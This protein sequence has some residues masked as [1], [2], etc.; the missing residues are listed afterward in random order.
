MGL[1]TETNAQYYAGQQDHGF[2]S[3][4]PNTDIVLNNWGFNTSA[5][6]AF[7]STGAQISSTSNYTLYYLINGGTNYVALA[8]LLYT[9]DAADE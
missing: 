1:I 2:I 3:V 4:G 5:V 8:C 9:S 7:D 6:S